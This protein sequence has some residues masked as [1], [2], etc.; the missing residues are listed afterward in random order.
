MPISKTIDLNADLG[1]GCG[2]D[3]AMLGIV[4]SV[5]IACGAHAGDEQTMHETVRAA[6]LND[7]TIGAHVSY[8]DRA[9][10]GRQDMDLPPGTLAA[11]I[12]RQIRVLDTI[13]RETGARVRYVKAH[14]ALYNRMVDDA[15]VADQVLSALRR[16]NPALGILTL[17][18]SLAAQR[19]QATG[20]AV[21]TE[22]FADRAYTKTG[23]L[24]ARSQA[25][26]VI[27]DPRQVAERAVDMAVTG[28]VRSVTGES[29]PVRAQ[30]LCVHGDTPGAV[31][32]ARAVR[33]ALERAGA[34]IAP[35]A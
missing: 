10:F 18:G 17:A 33:E 25:G 22:A 11:E 21:F 26:A 7:V 5:N 8:P 28:R 35:F 1:E 19:A 2:D 29:L 30:S 14:G 23:R 16:V 27:T 6:T 15:E 13:A 4:S 3:A 9:N 34:R 24:L 32:L 12:T 31:M 20:I